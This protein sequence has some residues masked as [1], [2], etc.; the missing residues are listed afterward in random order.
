VDELIERIGTAQDHINLAD[1]FDDWATNTV[2]IC[3]WVHGG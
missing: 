3:G 1:I 2:V